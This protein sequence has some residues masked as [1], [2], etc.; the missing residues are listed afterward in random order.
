MEKGN[1]V[2]IDPSQAVSCFR[3]EI[4]YRIARAYFPSDMP[5]QLKQEG[6]GTSFLFPFLGK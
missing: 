5:I 3:Y 1:V 4:R 2:I 6:S